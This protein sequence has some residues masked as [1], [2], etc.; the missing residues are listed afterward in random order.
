MPNQIFGLTYKIFGHQIQKKKTQI[1]ALPR[2]Q[3]YLILRI[4]PANVV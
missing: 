3:K 1:G 4:K 2:L